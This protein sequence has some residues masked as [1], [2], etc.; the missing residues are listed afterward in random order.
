MSILR[1]ALVTVLLLL[2]T[3]SRATAD[4]HGDVSTVGAVSAGLASA[5]VEFFSWGFG[6]PLEVSILMHTAVAWGADKVKVG[7]TPD[8]NVNQLV[9]ITVPPAPSIA[10][11]NLINPSRIRSANALLQDLPHKI[12]PLMS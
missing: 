11:D 12:A 3:T 6:T 9:A 10:S 5:A 8:Q 1:T 7:Y 2:A 4:L